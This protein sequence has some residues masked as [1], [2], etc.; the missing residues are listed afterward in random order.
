MLFLLFI[1]H[2][3]QAYAADKVGIPATIYVP[4]KTSSAK[5]RVV[6]Q[7]GGCVE[8]HGHDCVETEVKARAA[9]E[10]SYALLNL[11]PVLS[12]RSVLYKSQMNR[13]VIR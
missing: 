12:G 10:A 1:K 11:H 2:C 4:L 9:S 3:I 7:F 8:Y 13:F 5:L 6:K